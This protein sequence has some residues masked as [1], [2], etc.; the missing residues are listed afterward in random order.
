MHPNISPLTDRRGA[1]VCLSV[2]TPR[3]HSRLGLTVLIMGGLVA[4]TCL[5]VDV[6]VGQ[7]LS[8][9][10]Q[11]AG[12]RPLEQTTRPSREIIVSAGYEL[13]VAGNTQTMAPVPPDE[14]ASRLAWAGM[15][16]QDGWLA[17]RGQSLQSVATEF[18]RHNERQLI[19]GDPQTGRLQVGGKFR[20]TD[21]EGFVA[22]LGVTHGVKAIVS[23]PGTQ[24]GESITLTGGT[25]PSTPLPI[26]APTLD[27]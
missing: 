11:V 4:C 5:A 10:L 23:Q 19:I 21:L 20:V 24:F 8:N 16:Q 13:S 27:K 22:A 1:A 9:L 14:P 7:M 17:F 26:P 3:P 15:Y 18:N 2:K 25:A 6:D 12:L